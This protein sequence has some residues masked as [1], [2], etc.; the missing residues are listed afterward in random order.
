M[1]IED[2]PLKDRVVFVEGAPRSGTTLLI[3]LL[4]VHPEIAAIVGESHLFDR[5][6]GCLFENHELTGT[7]QTYLASYLSREELRNAVRDLC[8]RVL[9]TMQD[10]VKPDAR[11]VAEKTPARKGY[12]EALSRKLECYPDAR[13]LHVVRD[14]EEVVRSLARAPWAR[15][16][17]TDFAENWRSAVETARATLHGHAGYLETPY[18]DLAADPTRAMAGVFEWLGV[19]HDGPVLERVGALSRERISTH[20][21]GIERRPRDAGSERGS[22]GESARRS[23]LARFGAAAAG[24]IARGASGRGDRAARVAQELVAAARTG[25]RARLAALTTDSVVLQLRS[26]AG[27]LRAVGDEAREAMLDLA[28]ELFGRQFIA[29]SWAVTADSSSACLLISAIVSDGRRVDVTIAVLVQDTRAA[30]VGVVSAGDPRGRVPRHWRG[31]AVVAE[32]VSD[33]R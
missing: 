2:S 13:Y 29:E 27:D 8:D 7:D 10:R 18:G 21:P 6:V 1:G 22:G 15:G 12:A 24:A 14:R 16:T 33:G 4:A 5:G 23:S 3:S 11:L 20:G 9:V 26:G 17:E 25:D 30:Q 19:D 31:H 28:A 32:E